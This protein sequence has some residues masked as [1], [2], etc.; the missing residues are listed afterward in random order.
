MDK[1]RYPVLQE[2]RGLPR[3]YRER[4]PSCKLH[5]FVVRSEILDTV[6]MKCYLSGMPKLRLGLNDEVMFE[7]TGR[8]ASFIRNPIHTR[9]DT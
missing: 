7:I 1:R 3:R 6:K 9:H 5:L 4:E 8:S 2:E